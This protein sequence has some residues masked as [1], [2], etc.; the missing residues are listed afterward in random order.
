MVGCLDRGHNVPSNGRASLEK[1]A[2]VLF[3]G[4]FGAVGG[5]ACAE[6]CRKIGH[7]R[8]AGCR[9]GGEEDLGRVLAHKVEEGLRPLSHR[10]NT[11]RRGCSTAM[12]LSAP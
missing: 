9:G 12:T 2:R 6:L 1:E 5:E 11:H 3:D 10:E 7:E 4:E 8:T